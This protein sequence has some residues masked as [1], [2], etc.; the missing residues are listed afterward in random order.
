MLTVPVEVCRQSSGEGA[1]PVR[2][3]GPQVGLRIHDACGI[4]AVSRVFVA[5][6]R[7]EAQEVPELVLRHEALHL[8]AVDR[9]KA[10]PS[11][12]IGGD[13]RKRF[14]HEGFTPFTLA[15]AFGSAMRDEEQIDRLGFPLRN[16][17]SVL[18]RELVDLRIREHSACGDRDAGS[19]L[20]DLLIENQTHAARRLSVAFEK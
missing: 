1:P 15:A 20:A 5:F 11:H 3:H 2:E 6:I 10:L 18:P 4:G 7:D 13:N 9:E 14:F 12:L 16:Q 19:E 8:V 17:V